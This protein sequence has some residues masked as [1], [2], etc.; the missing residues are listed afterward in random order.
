MKLDFSHDPD[1][2]KLFYSFNISPM[3]LYLFDV[4][5][6]NLY[7]LKQFILGIIRNIYF[8]TIV[9]ESNKHFDT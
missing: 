5:Y 1:Q 4:L 7:E 3:N 2:I 6:Y 9:M 8:L